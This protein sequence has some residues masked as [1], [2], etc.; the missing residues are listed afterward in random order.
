VSAPAVRR[1]DL[2]VSTLPPYAFGARA[3]VWWGTLGLLTIEGTVFGLLVASYIYLRLQ[4]A[5][6]PPFGTPPPALGASIAN[7]VVLLLTLPP[8]IVAHRAALRHRRG[9]A[10]AALAVCVV[11]G[12]AALVLRWF[13]LGALGC[14]WDTHAYGSITWTILGTHAGHLV[15]STVE[16]VLLALLLWR[17][18]LERKHYVDVTV[19]AVYWYFVVASWLPLSVLVFWG[20]R[21]LR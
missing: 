2:D 19:N 15:A 16:N 9:A 6:W 8:M 5:Q 17:G 12:L 13:E 11:G 7:L 14:R 3:P 10:A 21:W 1:V 18:P 4:A 20:P